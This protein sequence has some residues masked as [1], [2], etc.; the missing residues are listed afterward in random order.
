MPIDSHLSYLQKQRFAPRQVK[1][2]PNPRLG[3]VVVIPCHDEPDL[4]PTLAS[5]EACTPPAAAVE[6]ILVLNAPAGASPDLQARQAA[7]RQQVAT[8]CQ[9]GTRQHRYHLLDFPALPPRQA[10]V[11]L[12]RKIGL[13]EG[14]DRLEQAGQAETGILVCLDAD[15]TVDPDYLCAIE[16]HFRRYPRC[17]AASI[18]FE[19]PLQ[20]RDYAPAVYAGIIHYELYLR[21]YI[22]ALRAAGYP[23]AWH[24]VG[25]AIAVRATA[26]ARRGGMNRRQAGEDFYFL[27]KFWSEGTVM[28]LPATCV[29]PSPRPSH[30]VPFGTG[31]AIQGWLARGGDSYPAFDPG[32]FTDL[33]AL[34]AA[35][36]QA[37]AGPLPPLPPVVE[38]FLAAQ[39]HAAKLAEVR[40]HVRGPAA[41]VKRWYHWFDGL[42]VL[43]YAHFAREQGYPDQPVEV[44][45]AT[46]ARQLGAKPPYP[47]DAAGWLAWYRARERASG[48][49][50]E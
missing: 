13:D 20:G 38:A 50:K 49:I 31:K 5:L 17:E 41:F 1:E 39:G 22:E 29:R 27:Q 4:R 16:A 2:P 12:A 33:A 40:Q 43:Q 48:A 8:W 15:A 26:Y 47:P 45:A 18:Y 3:L 25:S 11:G 9:A 6:V 28:A 37:Y 14:L 24:A 36:P 7:T 30:R 35:I 21:Y 19:H 23:Q 32:I 34:L 10:G 46:L 44:A 42:K